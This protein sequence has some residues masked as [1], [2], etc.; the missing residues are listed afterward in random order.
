MKKSVLFFVLLS[1]A[2]VNCWATPDAELQ[3]GLAGLDAQRIKQAVQAGAQLA[4]WQGRWDKTV[5]E[6][7]RAQ[8]KLLGAADQWSVA[9]VQQVSDLFGKLHDTLFI[10]RQA[11]LDFAWENGQQM[12]FQDRWNLQFPFLRDQIQQYQARI[13]LLSDERQQLAQKLIK[14]IFALHAVINNR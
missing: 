3:Q 14:Q 11:G 4:N 2:V 8:I 7:F 1:L 5:L 10:L 6:G 13:E 9:D 12:S